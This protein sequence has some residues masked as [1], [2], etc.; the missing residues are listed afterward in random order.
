MSDL[1]KAKRIC[2]E[3]VIQRGYM[4]VN[5]D[6]T[7]KMKFSKDGTDDIVVYVNIF[8]KLN[9]DAMCKYM[10]MMNDDGINHGIVLYSEGVTSTTTKTIQQTINTVIEIFNIDELQFNITKHVLQPSFDKIVNP[11]VFKKKYGIKFPIMKHNDPIARF[12]RYI[13]GDIIQITQSEGGLVSYR[14]VK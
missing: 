8:P 4:Y 11:N 6:D 9:K 10:K 7:D 12:Y 14:I 2:T 5:T 13:K 3:M 1:E